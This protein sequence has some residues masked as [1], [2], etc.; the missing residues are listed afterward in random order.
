MVL[1]GAYLYSETF[2]I[3]GTKEHNWQPAKPT[4]Y[5]IYKG[6]KNIKETEK[7]EFEG[8]NTE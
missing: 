6:Y 1:D 5:Y 2:V 7:F 4:S 3:I 8:R